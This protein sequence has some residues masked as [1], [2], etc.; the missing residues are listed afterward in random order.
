MCATAHEAHELAVHVAM[1]AESEASRLRQANS[2]LRQAL[3]SIKSE[4]HTIVGEYWGRKGEFG[5]D[6]IEK[7]RAALLVLHHTTVTT[8][9]PHPPPHTRPHA[10]AITYRIC[11]P[12][13]LLLS[14]LPSLAS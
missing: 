6:S 9:R 4:L 3:T 2:L 12:L 8:P 13:P 5:I 14:R 10:A 11:K 1:A 7:A